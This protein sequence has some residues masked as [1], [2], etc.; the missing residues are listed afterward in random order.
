MCLTANN[1]GLQEEHINISKPR[2][3]PLMDGVPQKERET[4]GTKERERGRE[5]AVLYEKVVTVIS[6]PHWSPFCYSFVSYIAVLLY[7]Q[8]PATASNVCTTDA[9]SGVPPPPN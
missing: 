7:L 3:R 9:W 2:E 1:F 6:S 4:D 8:L 5:D